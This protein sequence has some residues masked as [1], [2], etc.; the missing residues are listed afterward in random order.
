M[1][2]VSGAP[3]PSSAPN[4]TLIAGERARGLA[5]KRSRLARERAGPYDAY[6]MRGDEPWAYHEGEGKLDG[7]IKATGVILYNLFCLISHTSQRKA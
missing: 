1:G 5:A 6:G 3:L 7:C 2:A 4:E